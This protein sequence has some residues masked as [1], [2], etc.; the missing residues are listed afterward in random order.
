MPVNSQ[1]LYYCIHTPMEV[2]QKILKM[3]HYSVLFRQCHLQGG[4]LVPF[5]IFGALMLDIFDS[6]S[7]FWGIVKANF[8]T[9]YCFNQA[10]RL[11]KL[12][13]DPQV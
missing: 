10:V 2:C 3:R 9:L 8:E 11:W 6:V 7:V 5:I 1:A 12:L 13:F 4:F